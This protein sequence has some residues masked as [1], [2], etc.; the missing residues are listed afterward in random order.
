MRQDAKKILAISALAVFFLLILLYAY[1][2][3]KDLIFGV[4]IRNV[5]LADGSTVAAQVQTVTG[6]ARNAVNLTL[7]GREISIDQ[8]GDFSESLALLP[9]YTIISLQAT[10]KFGHT[11][12]KDYQI[13]YQAQ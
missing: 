2:R 12:E 5:N 4:Q 1:F 11:D 3:S 10:D 13:M 9:G 8:A 7:N 6:N